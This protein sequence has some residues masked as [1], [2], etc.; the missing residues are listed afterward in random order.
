MRDRN[1]WSG[2]M[3]L[4]AAAAFLLDPT[5]GNRRRRCI[6][7]AITRAANAPGDAAGKGGRDLRSSRRGAM[8]VPGRGCAAASV[9]MRWP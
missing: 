4:G 1:L 6:G 2:S 7:D 9:Q 5:S 8:A 3:G